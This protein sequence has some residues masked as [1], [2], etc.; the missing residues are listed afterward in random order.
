MLLPLMSTS[1]IQGQFAFLLD[2]CI[3]YSQLVNSLRCIYFI[4]ELVFHHTG[5][6]EALNLWR[7]GIKAFRTELGAGRLAQEM[8]HTGS[9]NSCYVGC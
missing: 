4:Y 7:K 2:Y 5:C 6:W 9:W 1:S 8:P 3:T